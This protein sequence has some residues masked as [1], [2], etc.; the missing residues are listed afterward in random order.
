LTKLSIFVAKNKANIT[1]RA[2]ENFIVSTKMK[3]NIKSRF[4]LSL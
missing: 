4:F 2:F 1:S 3:K